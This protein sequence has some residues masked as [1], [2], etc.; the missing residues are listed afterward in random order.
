[1][2]TIFWIVIVVVVIGGGWY[3]YTNYGTDDGSISGNIELSSDNSL[4]KNNTMVETKK[5]IVACDFLPIIKK[6]LG[7]SVSIEKFGDV[8]VPKLHCSFKTPEGLFGLNV[9]I[10]DKF[11][12]DN[13]KSVSSSN[14]DFQIVDVKGIGESAYWE[15][16][17]QMGNTYSTLVFYSKGVLSWLSFVND[18]P[19]NR[20][21]TESIAKDIVKEL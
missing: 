1:M 10:A 18:T 20:K 16:F 13:R 17:T 9:Q 6:H 19:E 15:H 2:K 7:E 12:F 14:K 21:I 4:N 11:I 3:F 8:S 5:E